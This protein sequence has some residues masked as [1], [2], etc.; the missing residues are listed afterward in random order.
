MQLE[1]INLVTAL[2]NLLP[3]SLHDYTIIVNTENMTSQQ[4]LSSGAGKDPV[5]CVCA[6]YIW[7]IA[8]EKS[9][10]VIIAHK[11][12]K[13]IVFADALSWISFDHRL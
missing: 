4:V 1:A 11:P 8:A 5:I 3:P 12:G 7:L 10:D 2:R 13:D 9:T 6:H